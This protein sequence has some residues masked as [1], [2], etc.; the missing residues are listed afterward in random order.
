[1]MLHAF[2]I[3]ATLAMLVLGVAIVGAML[4]SHRG[5]VIG[6]LFGSDFD[7]A[8]P[9]MGRARQR[10]VTVRVASA[11]RSEPLRAAA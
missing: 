10:A 4:F 2:A 11:R 8:S 1:M 9:A 7:R 6:A 3:T 5:A